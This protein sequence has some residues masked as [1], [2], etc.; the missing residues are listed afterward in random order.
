MSFRSTVLA[1]LNFL[2]VLY[3]LIF[4]GPEDTYIILYYLG[5]KLFDVMYIN[6]SGC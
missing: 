4:I 1:H 3:Y 6:C 2:D 5:R